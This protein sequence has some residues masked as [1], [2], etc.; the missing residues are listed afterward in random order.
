MPT[1]QIKN[2]AEY[3]ETSQSR[4][5]YKR[6]TWVALPNKHDGKGFRRLAQH[7]DATQIFCA[8]VLIVQ[9]A[10]KMKVR[11][12]LVDDDGPLDADDLSVKTGFPV[13]IFDQA[14]SVLTEPKIGWMEVVDE[15]S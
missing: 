5:V 13:D 8:W 12:L 14:F 4:K 2:W 15:R 11:G 9:V 10:S 3:F 6:L 1:Y 7:P